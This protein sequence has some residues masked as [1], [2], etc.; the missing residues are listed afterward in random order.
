MVAEISDAQSKC[1]VAFVGYADDVWNRLTRFYPAQLRRL[2]IL[3]LSC[4][5]FPPS[6]QMLTCDS[7]TLS[8]LDF[9]AGDLAVSP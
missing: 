6:L 8:D 7:E 3:R 5:Q 1:I 2:K 4:E 9:T